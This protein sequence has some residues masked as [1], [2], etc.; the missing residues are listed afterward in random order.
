MIC[1]SSL[2]DFWIEIVQATNQKTESKGNKRHKLQNMH[3]SINY[4]HC[5]EIL[6]IAAS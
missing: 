2:K 5:L 1:K 4:D 3:N 6:M